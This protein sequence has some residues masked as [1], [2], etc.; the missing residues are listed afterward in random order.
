MLNKMKASK[1][2]KYEGEV[3]YAQYE[4]CEEKKI[5]FLN[6][7]HIRDTGDYFVVGHIILQMIHCFQL[8]SSAEI[9]SL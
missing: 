2:W 4:N 3:L 6:S 8:E 9:F 1:L 7:I 5:H